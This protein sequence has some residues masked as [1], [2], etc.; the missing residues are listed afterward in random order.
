[1]NDRGMS[2]YRLAKNLG[3]SQSTIAHWLAGDTMPQRRALK[4]LS[5]EFGC[6]VEYLLGEKEKPTTDIGD[7]FTDEQRLI[8]NKL[9]ALQPEE[10]EKKL[11][12]IRLIL[13]L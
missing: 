9:M 10:R 7:G 2:P 1:M 4:A 3:C 13:D 8:F 11:Q 6:T 12:A 5:E